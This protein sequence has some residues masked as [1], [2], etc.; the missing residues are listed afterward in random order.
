MEP[1]LREQLSYLVMYSLRENWDQLFKKA[2]KSKQSYFKFLTSIIETECVYKKDKARIARIKRAK[3]PEMWHMDTFPFTKQPQL[4]K[5]LVLELY[6]SKAYMT[7]P[8]DLIF[9]GP[10]GCGKTGL[11]TAFLI[12]AINEGA[13]GLFIE[14]SKLLRALYQA[15]GDRSEDKVLGR[16]VSYDVLLIDEVG[17]GNIEKEVTGLFFELMKARNRKKSTIITTQHGFSEWVSFIKDTHLIAA[18]LDRITEN[19]AVFNMKKCISIRPKNIIYGTS[20]K[21]NS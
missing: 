10:T 13:K 20:G 7:E 18:L 21:N 16:L 14:Y 19:C 17:Y 2:T 6:D 8:K 12:H 1:K 5:K 11:G 15:R 3:I 9:I 4:K